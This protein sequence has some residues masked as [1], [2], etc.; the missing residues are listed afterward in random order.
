[1]KTKKK[2]GGYDSGF[3]RAL[4]LGPLKNA[5]FHPRGVSYV[6]TKTYY[7]DFHMRLGALDVYFEA[8]GRFRDR[9]EAR[10]YVDVQRCLGESERI[11]FVF[12]KPK[13][14]MPGAPTRA[15]N[16]RQTMAEWA[17]KNG[18]EYSTP[19]ELPKFLKHY[20]H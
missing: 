14:P 1:M 4:H 7:P 5:T 3:E 13:T 17:A 16:T 2:L 20:K 9:Q 12:Q 19:T 10:K 8:K 18:F 6:Q 11:I 15:D